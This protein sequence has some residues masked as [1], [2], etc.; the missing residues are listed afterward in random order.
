MVA[1]P[2]NINDPNF[3]KQV[4]IWHNQQFQDQWNEDRHD[5]YVMA[6]KSWM[7]KNTQQQVLNLPIDAPLTPPKKVMYNDDGTTAES[8]FTDLKPTVLATAAVPAPN[9]S[10]VYRPK[11]TDPLTIDQKLD[12]IIGALS[13]IS[14]LLVTM[15]GKK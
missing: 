13:M 11:G 2:T 1:M 8:D 9:G 15:N 5:T 6:Y 4:E 7:D 12:N 14:N 10:I 3:L